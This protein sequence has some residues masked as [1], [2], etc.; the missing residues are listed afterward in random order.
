MNRRFTRLTLGFS[1]KIENHIHAIA[2]YV[3]H[4]NFCKIHKTLRVTPAMEAGLTDHVWEL[5]EL[6]ELLEEKEKKG[7]GIKL[8][9]SSLA[10]HKLLW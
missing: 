7:E 8:N 4:Y 2:L 5:D 3:F 6:V 10:D 1:E 9:L